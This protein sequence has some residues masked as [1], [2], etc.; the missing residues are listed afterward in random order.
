MPK[1]S[2][3]TGASARRGWKYVSVAR[4][5]FAAKGMHVDLIK[6]YGSMELAPLVGL[7][8]AIVDVVSTGATL[9]ANRLRAV[10]E[11][12]AISARLIVNQAALKTKRPAVQKLLDAFE[13]AVA[14]GAK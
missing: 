10:E 5:H 13:A 1:N 4:E 6:L 14:Q 8:E 3:G 7:A 12:R 9:R 2:A 11:I